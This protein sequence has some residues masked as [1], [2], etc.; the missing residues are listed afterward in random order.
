MWTQT[1]RAQGSRFKRQRAAKLSVARSEPGW[2]AQAWPAARHLFD[3]VLEQPAQR[4]PKEFQRGALARDRFGRPSSPA[5]GKSVSHRRKPSGM[6][7][8]SAIH[9]RHRPRPRRDRAILL[10]HKQLLKIRLQQYVSAFHAPPV[11]KRSQPLKPAQTATPATPSMRC[12]AW[13]R[14]WKKASCG[15]NLEKFHTTRIRHQV[16]D[17]RLKIQYH[18]R[19]RFAQS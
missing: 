5:W 4:C 6:V 19:L 9:Q 14:C 18:I 16:I 3:E 1:A 12:C 7:P 8:W 2:A 17:R 11:N 15:I 13:H 10:T